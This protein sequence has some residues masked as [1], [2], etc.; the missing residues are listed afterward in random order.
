[1]KVKK[2]KKLK[3][4]NKISKKNFLKGGM[5]KPKNIGVHR[6]ATIATEDAAA[7]HNVADEEKESVLEEVLQQMNVDDEE[8]EVLLQ[9]N[10]DDEEESARIA[11]EDEK[12]NQIFGTS[13]I[14]EEIRRHAASTYN[15]TR[16]FNEVSHTWHELKAQFIDT[17]LDSLIDNI[18]EIRKLEQN[19]D[20]L[21][22][23]G[24]PVTKL[25]KLKKILMI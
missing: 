21:E 16:R 14:L 8:E 3:H 6:D 20:D 13:H 19:I 1:M 24:L 12:K 18:E 4:K 25:A 10:A 17:Q 7:A 15:S 9:M 23:R 11:V 5:F 22:N 2:S